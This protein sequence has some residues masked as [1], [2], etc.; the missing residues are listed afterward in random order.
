MF[1][2]KINST[3]S[4][5]EP[6]VDMVPKDAILYDFTHYTW[7]CLHQ[8]Q[9]KRLYLIHRTIHYLYNIIGRLCGLV[10]SSC[11]HIQRSP[12]LFPALPKFSEK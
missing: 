3:S 6:T 1:K 8:V 4:E 7:T 5:Q 2:K 11:L 10:V 12:V 9:T